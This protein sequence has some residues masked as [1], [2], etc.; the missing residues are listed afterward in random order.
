MNHDEIET[1]QVE[2]TMYVCLVCY[3]SD[4]GEADY[5]IIMIEKIWLRSVIYLVYRKWTEIGQQN[6]TIWVNFFVKIM[7]FDKTNRARST[8][9]NGSYLISDLKNRW[10]QSS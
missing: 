9:I 10:I 5:V 7:I 8:W 1:R 6:L 2:N 4:C 3:D